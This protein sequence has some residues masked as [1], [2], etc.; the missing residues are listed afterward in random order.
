MQLRRT[1]AWALL[2]HG[3]VFVH[4]NGRVAY[5][6]HDG[7]ATYVLFDK[8]EEPCVSPD[9]K[10]VVWRTITPGSAD[11]LYALMWADVDGGAR[12]RFRAGYV[13]SPRFSPDGTQLL[14]DEVGD[15]HQAGVMRGNRDGSGAQVVFLGADPVFHADWLPDGKGIITHDR[16]G[17]YWVTLDGKVL[18]QM[19][20]RDITG[21]AAVTSDDRFLVSPVDANRLVYSAGVDADPAMQ[22]ALQE[23]LS[24]G[25][26]LYDL[27]TQ[28]RT[29]LTGA[30][31]YATAPSWARD[32]KSVFAHGF[33]LGKRP[34]RAGI[35]RIA[36]DGAITRIAPGREPSQ[37]PHA[38]TRRVPGRHLGRACRRPRH[39]RSR[40]ARHHQ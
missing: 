18:R 7:D 23:G 22:K 20:V 11:G 15:D 9:G 5:Q 34:L 10:R 31:T 4:A 14:W 30:D 39:S 27:T 19:A 24:T 26:F 25:I 1:P 6:R 37:W 3:L 32:G 28:R 21:G 2:V 36:V 29:R 33:R 8:G 16:D 13:S 17:V 12:G 35:L 38:R 40:R